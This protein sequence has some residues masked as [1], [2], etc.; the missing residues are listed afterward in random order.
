M[1]QLS[2]DCFAFG[3][4]MMSVAE[5][6]ALIRERLHAV[7]SSETVSLSNADGRILAED[8]AA[9]LDLPPFA[10]SAVDG[11]AICGAS[12]PR[13]GETTLSVSGH[14]QAG[15]A[16][17][18]LVPGSAARVFTGA[19]MPENADTVYM[20]E[21]VQLVD[22]HRVS[23][24]A[25]LKRGANTRPAGEDVSK[26]RT[27]LYAG[28]RLRPQDIALA[29]ALGLTQLTVRARVRVAIFSTG[30]ELTEPGET[31]GPAQLFDSNRTMLIA[32]ARR[33]GAAVTDLGILRD[34]H[35]AI[36]AALTEAAQDH[37]LILT[38]G[39]VS[40]GDADFVKDALQDT[41]SLVLWRIAIKPGRPV[42]MG[43]VSGTPLIGLPGNPVASF[44]TFAHV[45]R[46]A[47][48]A[49]GGGTPPAAHALPLRAAFA[50]RKKKD[51]REY[52]RASLRTGEDGLTEAVKFPRE[53]AGLISSLV[54]TD[55]LVELP[56]DVTEI[57]EGDMVAF[58]PYETLF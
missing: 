49:L 51:R 22:D 23:L 28:R 38:S 15:T 13:E 9:P 40:T 56:E 21:D 42:A 5:A 1:A 18:R 32:M 27:V 34:D 3:G 20:Q 52:V 24:P 46:P 11:Y 58:I 41:G 7:G 29:A 45:A 43:I 2:D 53:G 10:N 14:I 33:L 12:I 50:Y 55:G 26:G 17:K 54:G 8:V 6:G 39:G 44:V 31:R 36:A 48:L 37:D 35:A 57:A 30:N 16:P 25:G 4:P 19:P 47:I